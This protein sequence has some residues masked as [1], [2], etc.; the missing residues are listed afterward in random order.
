LLH[1]PMRLADRQRKPL[2]RKRFPPPAQPEPPPANDVR[3]AHRK[4]APAPSLLGQQAGV[5]P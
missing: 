1:Q 4:K 5:R 2:R 3:W